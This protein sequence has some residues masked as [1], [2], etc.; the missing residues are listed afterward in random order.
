M[1]MIFRIFGYTRIFCIQRNLIINLQIIQQQFSQPFKIKSSEGFTLTAALVSVLIVGL[2]ISAV[3]SMLSFQHREL[4]SI[5]QQ[6]VR[7]NIKQFV[8]QTIQN[9]DTCD[10]HFKQTTPVGSNLGPFTIDTRLNQPIKDINIGSFRT[11]CDFTG[12][13]NIIVAANTPI[14]NTAQLT[15]KSIMARNIVKTT[16]AGEYKAEL[17]IDFNSP[18]RQIR[19]AIV[20]L[21]LSVDTASGTPKQGR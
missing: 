6:L 3:I 4:Q 19:P 9:P 17:T 11:S 2:S 12:T 5:K 16:T 20:D 14:R 7:A 21:F 10:C 1:M 13:D 15:T 18:T 8:L